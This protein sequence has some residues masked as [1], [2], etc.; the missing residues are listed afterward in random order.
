MVTASESNSG[1]TTTSGGLNDEDAF[2]T[3]SP[4]PLIAVGTQA[5]PNRKNDVSLFHQNIF[6]LRKGTDVMQSVLID[7]ANEDD[8]DVIPVKTSNL[9]PKPTSKS[10]SDEP[11]LANLKT[12]TKSTKPPSGKVPKPENSSAEITGVVTS[13]TFDIINNLPEFVRSTWG[14]IF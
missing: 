11:K 3:F 5:A 13:L 14:T 10:K 2:S 1:N 8:S 6:P 7:S 4:A 12:K 9:R